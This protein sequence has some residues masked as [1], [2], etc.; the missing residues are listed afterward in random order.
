MNKPFRKEEIPQTVEKVI[1]TTGHQVSV[2]SNRRE[3]V[4]HFSD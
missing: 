3:A 4:F 2:E 1:S